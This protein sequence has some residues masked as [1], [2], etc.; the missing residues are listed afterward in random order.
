MGAGKVRRALSACAVVGS[1][2]AF[3]GAAPAGAAP[4]ST[5]PSNAV[6]LRVIA[7]GDLHGN[8]LPP[9]GLHGEV[10]RSDGVSV[11]AGGAAYLAAY[12]RQLREQADNSVLYAV[13]DTWG[14]SPLESGLFHDEPTIALLDELD[15]TAATLGNHEL[16]RGY[17]EL[18]RLRDGG[19]H[20]KEGCLYTEP[21]EGANF[22]ILGAN[23]TT[24]DG[25]PAALPYSIDYV[26]GLPVG[27]IGVVPSN[28]P[29]IIRPDAIAGL[30][31]EDEIAAVNRTAD[32]LGALGVRSIVVLYKG[33]IGAID[34]DDPCPSGDDGAAAIATSVSPDVDLI[35]TSDGD[36]HFNCTYTDPA[37]RPRTVVQGASHGRILSVADLVIDR[38]SR[39]VLR[40]RTVVF[41][42]VVTHDIDP[43]PTTLEFVDRAVE[44]SA[45]VANRSIARIGADVTRSESPSGESA[46]GNLVADAQLAATRHLGAQIALMNPGGLRGDLLAGDGTVSYRETY[47]VQPF[48]SMLQVLDLTGAQLDVL[49]EQQFQDSPVGSEVERILAPSHNLTYTLDRLAPRGERIRSITIDGEAVDPERV[50]KVVMNNFLAGGGDG[51][52]VCTEAHGLVGAGK[53]LDALNNYLATRSR[54]EPPAVDRIRLH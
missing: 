10:V 30:Q 7:F 49:L 13:G 15:L 20:P 33:D 6:P 46:L 43:D 23:L 32:S 40:D 36:R 52:T 34:G 41:T 28:T 24:T 27:V 17:A 51:F 45:E 44:K 21:F 18:E 48:G 35:V 22:P 1:L 16:D 38:Q 39:E 14:S 29:D 11:L 53:D 4:T 31:F 19:C 8:L 37:G 3:G 42:Q 12:V 25:T 47:A 54:V 50:Y 2:V 9:Q 26:D 5:I